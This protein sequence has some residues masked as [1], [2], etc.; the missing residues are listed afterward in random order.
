MVIALFNYIQ[1][2]HL[3]QPKFSGIK[4]NTTM[5]Q[6][7][8][9][10]HQNMDNPIYLVISDRDR[11][12]LKVNEDQPPNFSLKLRII[13]ERKKVVATDILEPVFSE[14]HF[15][16]IIPKSLANSLEGDDVYRYTITMVEGDQ[17][18]PL[19][20]DHNFSVMGNL[21]V[22][23][24][25]YDTFHETYNKLEKYI[26]R[27]D[28]KDEEMN[29]KFYFAD[30]FIKDKSLVSINLK[31]HSP[32]SHC[33]VTLE[34]NVQNHYPLT[35]RKEQW[36][37]VVTIQNPFEN[38]I[39]IDMIP[40]LVYMRIVIHTNDPDNFYLDVEKLI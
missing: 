26:Y 37:E 8:L 18:Y 25:F 1:S 20:T 9:F 2:I 34:K 6:S 13:D 27:K 38:G 5:F 30:M 11:V 19:Y 33:V 16:V 4:E 39:P 23:E 40:E 3:T 32:Q 36:R 35:H 31:R 24:N 12:R 28:Y 17:E 21:H 15:S 10:I 7:D 22:K 29:N 14:N